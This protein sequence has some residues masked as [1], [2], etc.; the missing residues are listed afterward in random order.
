MPIKISQMTTASALD[1]TELVPLVQ[2]G[3]NVRTTTGALSNL[4][5]GFFTWQRY[6]AI[7]D[8]SSHLLSSRYATL[9]LA[10]AVYSFA[11]SLTQEIDYCAIQA[12]I[13][14]ANAAGGGVALGQ[15]GTYMMG[16]STLTMQKF[17]TLQGSGKR[18]TIIKYAGTADA[19]RRAERVNS[20]VAV[21]TAVR[22]LGITMTNAA[23]TGACYVDVGGTFVELT[24]VACTNGKFGI[25]FDQTELATIRLCDIEAQTADGAG[26][27]LTNGPGHTPGVT[28]T[29][30]LATNATSG[31][32][33]GNWTLATGTYN[34]DFVET[35]GG[36]HESR[37]AT[38]TNG[39]TA[40]TWVGGLS[41]ACN[42]ATTAAAGQ[43]TNRIFISENQFN[44]NAASFHI[45]DDGGINHCIIN[46]NFNSGIVAATPAACRFSGQVALDFLSNEMEG[47]QQMLQFENLTYYDGT[48]AGACIN[49]NIIGNT[50][51]MSQPNTPIVIAVGCSPFVLIGNWFGGN[52]ASKVT[53]AGFNITN[54]ILA[55]FTATGT[56][57][58]TTGSASFFQV[59]NSGVVTSGSQSV[60]G[61]NGYLTGAG[62]TITQATDKT[63][64]VTLNKPNGEIVM[65]AANLNATTTVSFTLTNSKIAANDV[66]SVMRKSG[67]TAASYQVWVDSVAAGSCV[68]CLRNITAGNL[69]EAV[70]LQFAVTAGVVA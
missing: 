50:I 54:I 58:D 70:T 64:G 7:G 15:P 28:F 16:T 3:G 51:S 9:A 41:A 27:W 6:G 19:I 60:S 25:I 42:A 47:G 5:G 35:V 32:L 21:H 53:G 67:G 33:T 13:N 40:V 12:A 30:A 38:L 56:I 61:K 10:Q 11:T 66:V 46:N 31:T 14:A 55:N 57:V 48:A 36:A 17:V 8:G 49:V 68:I 26:I 39:S 22:D 4:S 62:G 24:N 44:N 34:L 1:G 23:A 29:G 69:A 20:S 2:S 45:L 65:N 43:F 52:A 63:T 18:A 37:M 59:D